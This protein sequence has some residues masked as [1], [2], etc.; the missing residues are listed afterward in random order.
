LPDTCIRETTGTLIAANV[1]AMA[2]PIA[3][4][5]ATAGAKALAMTML[6]FVLRPPLVDSAWA[7]FREVQTR[8]HRYNPLL[9]P[10]DQP[11]IELNRATMER[12][13]PAMRRF[14]YDQ[15]RPGTYLEQ[16]GMRYPTVRGPDG[17]CPAPSP[18]RP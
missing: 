7:Y 10:G 4:Q 5:G 15:S 17:T 6:D 1:L 16:L 11:A 18:A 12:F 9:R 3:H 13:R 8:G 14:Y 2:T